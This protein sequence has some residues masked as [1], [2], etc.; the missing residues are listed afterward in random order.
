MKIVR[1]V[2]TSLIFVIEMF[3]LY[4]WRQWSRVI[5]WGALVAVQMYVFAWWLA[6][7]IGGRFW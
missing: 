1:D 2:G 3:A 6:G 5:A 4:Q 7:G